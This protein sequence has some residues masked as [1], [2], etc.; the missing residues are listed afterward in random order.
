MMDYTPEIVQVVPHDD[1]TVT[2]FFCDGKIVQY[3]AAPKLEKEPE[4][5]IRS[6]FPALL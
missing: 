5:L 4:M 3:D 1:Y 6:A 2:V